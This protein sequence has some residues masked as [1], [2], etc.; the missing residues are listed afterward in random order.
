MSSV[1][2][3]GTVKAWQGVCGAPSRLNSPVVQYTGQV[4]SVKMSSWERVSTVITS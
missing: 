4:L 3:P 2:E 1:S